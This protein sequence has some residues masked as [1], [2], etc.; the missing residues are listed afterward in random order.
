MLVK[1]LAA[2]APHGITV[3]GIYPGF[4]LTDID[5]EYIATDYFKGQLQFHCPMGRTAMKANSTALLYF[6]SDAPS[7]TTDKFSLSMAVDLV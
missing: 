2:E 3:N 5:R 4:F 7:Y 6:A 1:A